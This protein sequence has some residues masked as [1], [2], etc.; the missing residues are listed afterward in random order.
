MT[1]RTRPLA[2]LLACLLAVAV[3]T[4]S[5]LSAQAAQTLPALKTRVTGVTVYADQKASV[6]ASNL[7]EGYVL[8]S[9]LGGRN[10]RIKVQIIKQNG[11]TYLYDLNNRGEAEV[12]PLT[13]GDGTYTIRVLENTTGTKYAQVFTTTLEVKLRSEFLPF[14][15]PNQY[16]NY[17]ADSKTAAK[18]AELVGDKTS[19][20]EKVQGVFQYVTGNISYD[21]ALAQS[22][23]TGYLPEVDRVLEAKKGICFDYAAVMAA[24]LRSQ[25]IPCKLVIGYAG[26]V[27]HAWVDVYIQGTGWVDKVIYFDGQNWTLMDP[28]FVSSGGHSDSIMKYVTTKSNYTQAFAY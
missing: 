5:G 19:E 6:D 13:E 11:V 7:A 2:A 12:F 28:T 1:A 16:V 22:V 23:T 10:V 3:L 27:Y 20:L 18:A 8:V 17:T 15:Y 26:Q 25:N 9:Y 24:M 14:L 21:Y 4:V